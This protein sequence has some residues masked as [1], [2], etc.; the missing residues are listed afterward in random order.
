MFLDIDKELAELGAIRSK[1]APK[2]NRCHP[3]DPAYERTVTQIQVTKIIKRLTAFALGE[4]DGRG[5]PVV[6]TRSQVRAARMFLNKHI[7]D[8]KPVKL[9]DL[10]GG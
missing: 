3:A 5:R 6:M 10:H 7:P 4:N 8:L 2:R 1:Y 9:E